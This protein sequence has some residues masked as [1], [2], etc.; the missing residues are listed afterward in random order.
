MTWLRFIRLCHVQVRAALIGSERAAPLGRASPSL[1]PSWRTAQGT[2]ESSQRHPRSNS[3]LGTALKDCFRGVQGGARS[4]FYLRR[5]RLGPF[6]F[7]LIGT[8]L[9]ARRCAAGSQGP[10]HLHRVALS[11]RLARFVPLLALLLPSRALLLARR[12]P[13]GRGLG[14]HSHTLVPLLLSGPAALL[15]GLELQILHQGGDDDGCGSAVDVGLLLFGFSTLKLHLG[16]GQRLHRLIELLQKLKVICICINGAL[17]WVF[18]LAC[19]GNTL[20]GC[21]L[22]LR[23]EVRP[24]FTDEKIVVEEAAKLKNIVHPFEIQVGTRRYCAF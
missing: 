18:A 10:L 21:K 12:P 1:S 24:A 11:L 2:S 7:D 22:H 4:R 16:T 8:R 5:T 13:G 20:E 9:S 15:L 19:L 3:R 14:R 6:L 23:T 17:A